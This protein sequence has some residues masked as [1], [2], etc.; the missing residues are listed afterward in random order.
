MTCHIEGH[1]A[2]CAGPGS[3][4]HRREI[5]AALGL[6][7]AGTAAGRKADDLIVTITEYAHTYSRADQSET[8]RAD[9]IDAGRGSL[10]R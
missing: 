3:A 9:M 1:P 10:L 4:E 2:D 7:P 8:Y 5:L 6:D